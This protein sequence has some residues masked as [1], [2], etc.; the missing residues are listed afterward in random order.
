M[1]AERIRPPRQGIAALKLLSGGVWYRWCSL[2]A[3]SQ[4]SP[5]DVVVIII[6]ITKVERTIF[7]SFS[8]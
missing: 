7:L 2:R 3:R 6:E 8:D 1:F 5:N 4:I